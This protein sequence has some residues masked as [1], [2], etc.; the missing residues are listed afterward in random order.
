MTLQSTGIYQDAFSQFCNAEGSCTSSQVGPILR[1][2][3][4]NPAEAEIQVGE[5][6]KLIA[7]I[8]RWHLGGAVH[9][10]TLATTY[11]NEP[12]WC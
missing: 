3:G 6:T 5:E 12:W 9:F 10:S 7:C 2:F 11:K 4:Q 8:I 1:T